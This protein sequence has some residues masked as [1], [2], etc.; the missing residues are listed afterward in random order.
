MYVSLQV[1]QHG[2]KVICCVGCITVTGELKFIYVPIEVQVSVFGYYSVI[3]NSDRVRFKSEI[4]NIIRYKTLQ[5]NNS[6]DTDVVV[7]CAD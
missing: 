2:T 6:K 5:K 1:L 7:L 4:T 3:Q